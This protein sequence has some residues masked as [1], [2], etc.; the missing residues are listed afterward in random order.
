MRTESHGVSIRIGTFLVFLFAVACA[1]SHSSDTDMIQTS[2]RD[3]LEG[4]PAVKAAPVSKSQPKTKVAKSGQKKP[5]VVQA[6]A[7]PTAVQATAKPAAVQAAAKPAAVQAAAK[8]A[9][10]Q[11]AVKPAAV[12]AAAKPA[13]APK[14]AAKKQGPETAYVMADTLNVRSA[15][16][17][18]AAVVGKLARGS[19][20]KVTYIGEWA[21][22]G[23]GQFVMARFLSRNPPISVLVVRQ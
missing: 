8:P 16:K 21:K 23:E 17:M 19:M 18:N 14:V 2:V 6:A 10:V 9:A 11:A 12:Q 20:F 13:V 3:P 22:I 15:P 5:A 4:A 1:A 7:K